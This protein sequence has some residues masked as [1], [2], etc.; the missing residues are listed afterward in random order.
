MSTRKLP[1][2]RKERQSQQWK[3]ATSLRRRRKSIEASYLAL[4]WV[5][6]RLWSML[7]ELRAGMK[8]MR[9]MRRWIEVSSLV[10]GLVM[11]LPWAI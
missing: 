5:A 8:R 11:D 4:Q 1:R 3:M 2:S 9:M 10:R 7:W 6:E